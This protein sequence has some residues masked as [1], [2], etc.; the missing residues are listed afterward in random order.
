MDLLKALSSKSSA[1][2]RSGREFRPDR[3]EV[4]SIE[5]MGSRVRTRSYTEVK[6]QRFKDD[7]NSLTRSL[8]NPI[9]KL[10]FIMTTI[11]QMRIVHDQLMSHLKL[12][13]RT[14]RET[15]TLYDEEFPTALR[16]FITG[17]PHLLAIAFDELVQLPTAESVSP[18]ISQ[19]LSMTVLLEN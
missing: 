9:Y 2:G 12:A 1:T 13:S 6:N 15:G 7:T 19:L 11:K 3:I 8:R 16:D 14:I 10:V 5:R 18:L 17:D 4:W